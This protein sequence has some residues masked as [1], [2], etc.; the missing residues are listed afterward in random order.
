MA[1]K[2]AEDEQK[3][4]TRQDVAQRFGKNILT[5]K[6]WELK[7]L[8]IH[9]Q[10]PGERGR[11]Y[12]IAEDVDAWYAENEKAPPKIEEADRRKK[13]AD[14]T[15][16]E[17]KVTKAVYDVIDIKTSIAIYDRQ[18]SNIRA[19][20]VSLGSA[21]AGRIP[22]ISNYQERYQAINSEI[23]LILTELS[24]DKM[25]VK[26]WQKIIKDSERE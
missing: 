22:D 8:P 3:Y 11:K 16:A 18:C 9:H 24:V 5:I 10:S 19:K 21:L 1:K 14:A 12:Y 25:S 13:H 2:L 6:S 7:G 4:L 26:E 20:L 23:A 17:I 15:L